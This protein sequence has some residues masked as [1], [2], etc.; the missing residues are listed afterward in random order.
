[1]QTQIQIHRPFHSIPFPFYSNKPLCTT[2][3]SSG[4][5]RRLC[6]VKPIQIHAPARTTELARVAGAQEAALFVGHVGAGGG[7]A[8]AGGVEGVAAPAWRGLG[9]L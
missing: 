5:P 6:E 3:P 2:S 8:V 7:A 4:I 1:M 9:N